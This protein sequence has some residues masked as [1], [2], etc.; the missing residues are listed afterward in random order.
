[1]ADPLA[2]GAEDEKDIA[3]SEKEALKEQEI[4]NAKK[5]PKRGGGRFRKPRQDYQQR[6]YQFEPYNDFGW[7]EQFAPPPPMP[8]RQ[9]RPRVLGPCFRCGAYGHIQST[10]TALARP[11]PWLLQPVV[12]TSAESGSYA[13]VDYVYDVNEYVYM[14][15]CVS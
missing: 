4:A 13:C 8:Q 1:M 7:R 12:S 15:S 3:R 14:G 9:F 5:A 10:C 11:Y 2:D 6:S